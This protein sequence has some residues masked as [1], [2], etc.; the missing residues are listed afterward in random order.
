M[1]ASLEEIRGLEGCDPIVIATSAAD[2]EERQLSYRGAMDIIDSERPVF[3]MFGTAW[4]LHD[5]V[6]EMV[7]YILEPVKGSTDYNHLSVRAAAG[8]IL[9]RLAGNDR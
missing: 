2:C 3:L 4:G 7:D 1:E 9:D 8:I 6:L 5:E